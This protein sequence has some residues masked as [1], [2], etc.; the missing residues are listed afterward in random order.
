MPKWPPPHGPHPGACSGAVGR[1]GAEAQRKLSITIVEIYFDARG[2]CCIV[3]PCSVI[4]HKVF[5]PF[6][7]LW[8]R[9]MAAERV[10]Q[11][12]EGQAAPAH[13]ETCRWPQRRAGAREST[14]F[15]TGLAPALLS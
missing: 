1:G 8:A 13:A 11:G 7:P 3:I 6:P 14:A 10:R 12:V 9:T 15:Y 2:L 5:S 4:V